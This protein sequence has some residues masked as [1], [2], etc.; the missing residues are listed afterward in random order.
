[1]TI[2]VCH[3]RFYMDLVCGACGGYGV[4]ITH[5]RSKARCK[6]CEGEGHRLRLIEQWDQWEPDPEVVAMLERMPP[7]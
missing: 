5:D 6:V 3:D 7:A 2:R 4:V 1:M